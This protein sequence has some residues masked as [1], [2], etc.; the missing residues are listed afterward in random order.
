MSGTILPRVR[1]DEM[2]GR[3]ISPIP[4]DI[5]GPAQDIVTGVRA[6]GEAALRQYAERWDGLAHGSPL[7]RTTQ[8]LADA[9]ARLD[10]DDRGLL[11]RVAD[12]IEVFAAAQ[13][14]CLQ[15][16][17]IPIAGGRAGHDLIPVERAGCY[18]PGGRF[19]LPSSVL[20]TAVTARVA[21]VRE[22]WVATPNPSDLMLA[23]AGIA[24]AS[25][26]L[27]AGGAHGIAAM[28]FGIAVPKCGIIA[29]P[30][31]KWV[32][33]AKYLVSSAVG[34]DMLAG[35]SELAVLADD[36]AD[37]GLIAADLLAQAEHDDDAVPYLI[38]PD[39]SLARDV[40]AALAA[41]LRTL[42]TATTAARA[43]RNGAAVI[44]TTLDDALSVC[45][46]LAPE[47]LEIMTRD[48]RGVAA[49]IRN[50]GTVFIGPRSAEVLGDYGAGPN[51]VLPT[52]GSARYRS[53]LSVFTFLRAR[54]WLRREAASADSSTRDA[55]RLARLE[56]LE[57]HARAAERRQAA[58]SSSL[59]QS[60]PS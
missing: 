58:P 5:I 13:L 49:R 8:C 27:A 54:T 52:G 7:V 40:D 45:D 60:S 16:L 29:G 42:S 51:H 9:T 31:N 50:A 18:A 47:H 3:L 11:Q 56:G 59:S 55:I 38:T 23:A 41:Q 43:L 44:T 2:T 22:I 36:T 33:A 34:I 25:G 14:A 10:E 30:G 48:A 1:P 17:S 37:P 21:G 32:T 28:A 46:L 20:M 39:A 57:A 15:P 26:V 35:P 24:G 19:P 4:A 6:G 12:R 53:G